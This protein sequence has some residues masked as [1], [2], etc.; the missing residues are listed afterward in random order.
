MINANNDSFVG[1]TIQYRLGAFGFLFSDEVYHFGSP[2]AGL[3]DQ[4][5]ALQW[6]Q[7]NIHL[8]GGDPRQVT[9]GGLSAGGGSVMLLG[10]SFGGTLGISLFQNTFA[11]SP[12]LP[13]QYAYN[14]WIPSQSYYSFASAVGCPPSS[15]YGQHPQ[16][17]FE[18]LQGVSPGDL[19]KASATISQSGTYG[20]V[21]GY[22]WEYF[23]RRCRPQACL[24]VC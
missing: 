24:H 4:Q 2:N 22:S 9:I 12:Y 6:V 11:A 7:N 19:A 20:T 3:Y 8:F 17:I 13:M 23:R 1:I 5:F 18:C 14:D 21:S 10:T 15:P 16:T